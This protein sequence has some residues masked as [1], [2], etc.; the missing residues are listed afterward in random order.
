MSSFRFPPPPPPPPKAPSNDAHDT[1][2]SQRGGRGGRG[3]RGRGRGGPGRGRGDFGGAPRGGQ[4]RGNTHNRGGNRG[5][6]WQNQRHTHATTPNV[7]HQQSSSSISPQSNTF[8]TPAVTYNTPSI[9]NPPADPTAFVQAMS[10][11]ATP[12]GMQS[13]NAFASHMAAANSGSGLPQNAPLSQNNHSPPGQGACK[14]RRNERAMK[15]QADSRDKPTHNNQSRNQKPPRAK[16]KAAPAVPSF[17]FE[18]PVP[19]KPQPPSHRREDGQSDP[20]RRKMN[21]GLTQQQHVDDEDESNTEEEIDEEAA[22]AS[23]VKVK[24]GIVFEHEGEM[25]SLQTPAEITA[26]RKDRR[27]NFPT[28]QRILEKA[29]EAVEKRARELEFLRR[30]SG[31][32]NTAR[33]TPPDTKP[34]RD[35]NV[36]S[37]TQNQPRDSQKEL[38]QLRQKV[39]ESII[40]KEAPSSSLPEPPKIDLGLGYATDTDA[41]ESSVLSDSS[42]LSSDS[43]SDS[44]SDDDD[45][46]PTPISSKVVIETPAPP[47]APPAPR[48]APP[49]KPKRD[50]ID[51]CPQWKERG[52]CKYGRNCKYPHTSQPKM[53]GLY[54]RMV[55]QELEKRDRMALD[56]IK[57]L[58]RNG[59]LG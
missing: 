57:F 29:K 30:I 16:A 19:P 9:P 7:P 37:H 15:W 44:S 43:D 6:G 41:D 32:A 54:E 38:S 59:F 24:N 27:K 40:Q 2:N 42:V 23:N 49:T 53:V 48:A 25:I 3:D 56:A 47:P 14:T 26:W 28:Q 58:G 17:G 34:P 4:G 22:W 39:R 21:L 12:A 36:K 20:K 10:F 1:Y 51:V 8:H 50:K 13:M 55:E 33:D 46:P 18:I 45:K 52:T 35:Q 11:M 5:G 31:K